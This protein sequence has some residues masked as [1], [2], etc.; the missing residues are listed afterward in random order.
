MIACVVPDE[1]SICSLMTR[2]RTPGISYTWFG[3]PVTM[4]GSPA[5]RRP[6]TSVS[7]DAP[8]HAARLSVYPNTAVTGVGVSARRPMSEVAVSLIARSPNPAVYDR[9]TEASATPVSTATK[10]A[11]RTPPSSGRSPVSAK[12]V[13]P[14]IGTFTYTPYARPP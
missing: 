13:P 1:E 9:N 14:R 10:S 2:V 11:T 4:T 7:P 5:T 12:Y 3:S 6:T 8:S